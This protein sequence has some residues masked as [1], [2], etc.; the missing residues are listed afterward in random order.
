MRD[1]VIYADILII[2]NFA[3]DYFLLRLTAVILKENPKLLRTLSASFFA[4][5]T[6]LYIFLPQSP[7]FIEIAVRIVL[8]FIITLI[9]FGFNSFRAFIRTAA[10]FLGITFGYAGCMA[11]LYQIFKPKGMA[12]NNSVVYFDISPVVLIGSAAAFYIAV[13]LIKLFFGRKNIL[14][15]RVDVTLIKGDKKVDL[16]GICDTGNS[17]CD[18]FGAEAVI[19][20][21]QKDIAPLLTPEELKER[22]RAVPCKTVSGT[23]LLNGVRLDRAEI[24]KESGKIILKNITAAFSNTEIAEKSV[25]LNP[26]IIKE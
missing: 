12:I 16:T 24:K 14:S 2:V 18:P 9:G 13:S 7:V 4:S 19:L 21:N 10:L 6:S 1:V 8:C 26:E 23:A 5:L 20:C 22:Y 17:L 3:V 15:K 25:I 11:A